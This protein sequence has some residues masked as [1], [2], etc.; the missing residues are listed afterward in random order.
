[1]ETNLIGMVRVTQALFPQLE[2][3]RGRVVNVV[4]VAGTVALARS[5]PYCASKHAALA[6]SRGLSGAA[7]LRGVTV[8]TV[9]PGPV[10]TPGFSQETLLQGRMSRL[11]VIDVERCAARLLD[12]ADRGRA[13]VFAPRLYK[14]AAVAQTVAPGVVTRISTAFWNRRRPSTRDAGEPATTP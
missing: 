6:F 1:M 9:N 8:T 2:E 4:S 5:G 3:R 14:V 11:A 10:H 7:R 12:A 13:E